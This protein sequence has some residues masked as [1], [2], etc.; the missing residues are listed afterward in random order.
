MQRIQSLLDGRL[1]GEFWN[2]VSP[3]WQRSYKY[4]SLLRH[5]FA[6]PVTSSFQKPL[7][8]CIVQQSAHSSKEQ[9]PSILQRGPNRRQIRLMWAADGHTGDGHIS[10]D[11]LNAHGSLMICLRCCRA[12]VGASAE[13]AP[14][15]TGSLCP[16]SAA[17]PTSAP[18]HCTLAAIDFTEL[19]IHIA[20]SVAMLCNSSFVQS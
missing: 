5:A 17:P 14:F 3:S 20:C 7:S 9:L 1:E 13:L 8:I 4:H 18:A 11:R 2:T 12:T 10:N 16:C 15:M 6:V 19:C